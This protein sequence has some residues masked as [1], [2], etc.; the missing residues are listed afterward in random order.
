MSLLTRIERL[1]QALHLDVSADQM[2]WAVQVLAAWQLHERARSRGQYNIALNSQFQEAMVLMIRAA[3]G[4]ESVIRLAYGGNVRAPV[5]SSR[6]HSRAMAPGA[7][8]AVRGG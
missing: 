5:H 1:E 2:A 4:L 3:G 8:L 6:E 7:V